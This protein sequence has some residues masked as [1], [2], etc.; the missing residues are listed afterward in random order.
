MICPRCGSEN[1]SVQVVTETQ[2]KTRWCL[3]C[4]FSWIAFLLPKQTTVSHAEGVCQSCGNR[5]RLENNRYNEQAHIAPSYS[6]AP[7][8]TIS[9]SAPANKR[10]SAPTIAALPEGKSVADELEKYAVLLDKGVITQEEFNLIKGRLLGSEHHEPA[11]IKSNE[12]IAALPEPSEEQV[13]INETLL[14]ADEN[15]T[16]AEKVKS[17]ITFEV[18]SL[19]ENIRARGKEK[20]TKH[21]DFDEND[22]ELRFSPAKRAGFRIAFYVFAV[23]TLFTFISMCSDSSMSLLFCLYLG[24]TAFCLLQSMMHKK[25]QYFSIKQKTYRHPKHMLSCIIWVIAVLLSFILVLVL[26]EQQ[27]TADVSASDV[28]ST[29]DISVVT[30]INNNY[31]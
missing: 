2:R 31:Y 22:I 20:A 21:H 28:I 15:K 27:G 7:T 11:A 12:Q 18:K 14:I 5:F 1:V 3:G 24:A 13:E 19:F 10:V 4:F 26:P 9:N 8:Y 29:T 30:I 25:Q 17:A 23:I 6:S 16:F